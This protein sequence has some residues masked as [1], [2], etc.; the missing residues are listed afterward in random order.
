MRVHPCVANG[1]E[2]C[3]IGTTMDVRS[4]ARLDAEMDLRTFYRNCGLRA[5]TIERAIIARC[6]PKKVRPRP[7]SQA[8]VG[9]DDT[10]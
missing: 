1:P 5:E 8:R 6:V 10:Q 7:R 9:A 3:Q 4:L 2:Q